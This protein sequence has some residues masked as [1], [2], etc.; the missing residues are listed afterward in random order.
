MLGVLVT[1]VAVIVLIFAMAVGLAVAMRF[2]G[3][4][5]TIKKEAAR[6]EEPAQMRTDHAQL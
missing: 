2:L 4:E 1:A 3:Y 6:A 5:E